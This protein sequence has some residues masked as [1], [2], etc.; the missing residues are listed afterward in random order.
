MRDESQPVNETDFVDKD[1][2]KKHHIS[3]TLP[4]NTKAAEDTSA[5]YIFACVV[6]FTR[7]S[8]EEITTGHERYRVLEKDFVDKEFDN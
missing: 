4:D 7:G 8:E 2:D 3:C 1:S 5:N 6:D